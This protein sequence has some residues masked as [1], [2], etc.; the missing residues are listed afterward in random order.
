[1]SIKLSRTHW[2]VVCSFDLLCNE[3]F[4]HQFSQDDCHWLTVRM[5][6]SNSF[7]G[8]CLSEIPLGSMQRCSEEGKHSVTDQFR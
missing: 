2:H 3:R 1:M 4:K 6:F 8:L 7:W 5:Q